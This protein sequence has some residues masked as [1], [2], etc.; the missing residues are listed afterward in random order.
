MADFTAEDAERAF[1]EA[2]NMP[3]GMPKHEALERVARMSDAL[4][5][6]PLGVSCRTALIDSAYYLS[7]YDLMLAPFAWVRA[8]EEKDPEAFNE[9]EV[10]SLN[11]AHKWIA[12]GLR[13]IGR[14]SCRERV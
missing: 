9:Y 4:G 2:Y 14:A 11:W 10:H 8:A 3:T 5:H 12:T 1:L 7:R 6:L 13:Q